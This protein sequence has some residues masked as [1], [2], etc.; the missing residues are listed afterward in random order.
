MSYSPMA[1]KRPHTIVQHGE[2]RIDNYYWMRDRDDPEVLKYLRA[3]S[4]Y[5]EE[6]MGHTKPL[7]DMLYAEMKGRMMETDSSV[8]E[9][10][11]AYYYYT[12]TEAGKQYP[13]FCRKKE[14]LDHPEEILLDQ[15][16]LA[17]GKSFCSVGA[18]TISP[19][20]TKLAYSLD[21]EGGEVYTVYIKDL[22]KTDIYAE[23]IGNTFSSV[24]YHTGV[25]WANDSQTVYYLTLDAAQRPD[26]LWRH[27][28]GTDPSHDYLVFQENDEAYFLF[29]TKTRDDAYILT[30]H[31]ATRA[32]EMRFLSANEPNGE[33]KVL[34]PRRD[35][36]EYHAAHREGIFFIVTNYE[37]RNFRLMQASVDHPDLEQWQEVLPYREE[38]LLDYVDT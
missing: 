19:D 22:T 20:E 23:A 18:F 6:V 24:Y 16:L 27:R 38:V 2:T 31:H 13:I 5:L 33:L 35:G 11:G 29:I 36:V 3:E 17:E 34:S 14:S 9:K 15:N 8:P 26:C 30:H 7:Q 1:P 21:V 25:E 10:R 4:D 32:I 28:I 37:A 12:R